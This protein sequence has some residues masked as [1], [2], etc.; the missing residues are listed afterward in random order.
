MFVKKSML[1]SLA[2]SRRYGC[3]VHISAYTFQLQTNNEL[4]RPRHLERVQF[5]FFR[6][7][8]FTGK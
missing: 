1:L 7:I 6:L 2:L 5:R 4:L 3:A 8:K